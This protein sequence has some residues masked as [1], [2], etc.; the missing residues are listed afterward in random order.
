[1]ALAAFPSARPI[2]PENLPSVIADQ[3]RDDGRYVILADTEGYHRLWL[4]DAYPGQGRAVL[5]P[6][7]DHFRQR[8]AGALRFHRYLLG[9]R[10]GPVPPRVDLT[11]MQ[12]DRLVFMLRAFDGHEAG[13]SYRQIAAVLFDPDVTRVPAR[14]WKS[15]ALHARVFRLVKDAT[16]LVE[17]GY[18]RMLQGK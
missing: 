1:M 3:Q 16:A 15:S 2:I 10:S 6:F 14:D 8:L 13:A 12:R 11:P 4:T 7:D 18:R 17:G 5:I 9:E